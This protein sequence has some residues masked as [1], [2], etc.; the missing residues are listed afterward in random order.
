MAAE[1]K[2]CVRRGLWG[3]E[4]L[5]TANDPKT[6]VG[7]NFPWFRCGW[8]FGPPPVTR[9][10]SGKAHPWGP[11]RPWEKYKVKD[12][13][14]DEWDQTIDTDL[15][16]LKDLG[17]KALRWF[18]LADGVN[19]G[20]P[21]WDTAANRWSFDP[22]SLDRRDLGRESEFVSDLAILLKKVQAAGLQLLPV[23]ISF[24][25]C[26]RGLDPRGPNNTVKRLDFLS[27]GRSDTI[28]DAA[29]RTK[30]LDKVLTPLLTASKPYQKAIYA[31]ELINEP[32]WC[33]QGLGNNRAH[34]TVTAADM[35]TFIREGNQRINA[36]GF[37]ST[38]GYAKQ[39]TLLGST[40]WRLGETVHQFHYYPRGE[41]LSANP[42]PAREP[43]II[44]EFAARNPETS[45]AEQ[46]KDNQPWPD[47]AG[48]TSL[49]QSAQAMFNR[50]R[51]IARRGYDA[52]FVWSVNANS[53]K[54]PHTDWSRAT[55]D[56][57]KK[58]TNGKAKA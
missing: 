30:F 12:V 35:K 49:A 3:S 6:Q 33:T 28:A 41:R 17:V 42:F 8:D 31:W 10:A 46:R 48:T 50:L 14:G 24:E 27:G 18:I 9:D 51:W 25:F 7:V 54:D 43:C 39:K 15:R 1:P 20:M 22:P 55:R 21:R 38:V 47:F 11:R 40:D 56:D 23:L 52:A 19:Y 36:A 13:D 2:L 5:N 16:D 29:K 44:G 37:K 34:M 57:I 53:E 4:C 45:R 26:F 58:Y 32:E